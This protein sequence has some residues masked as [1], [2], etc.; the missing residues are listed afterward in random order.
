MLES[1]THKR[2]CLVF[3]LKCNIILSPGWNL[4]GSVSVGQVISTIPTIQIVAKT[5]PQNKIARRSALFVYVVC[6]QHIYVRFMLFHSYATQVHGTG[7]N[8]SASYMNNFAH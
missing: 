4:V 1:Y 8:R 6:A 7:R 5:T 3:Y 2:L